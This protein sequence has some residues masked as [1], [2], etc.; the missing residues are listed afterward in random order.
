MFQTAAKHCA[1]RDALLRVKQEAS[2]LRDPNAGG[3]HLDG[4]DVPAKILIDSHFSEAQCPGL[5]ESSSEEA[6]GAGQGCS[7]EADSSNECRLSTFP[8]M[9]V[10]PV[11]LPR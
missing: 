6:I 5:A 8:S 2:R 7:S 11:A 4:K 9:P 1:P 3:N 10:G